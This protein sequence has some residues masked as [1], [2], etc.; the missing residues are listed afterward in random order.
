[1]KTLQL[2]TEIA[3][4]PY[5]AHDDVAEIFCALGQDGGL[6][7]RENLPLT[8]PEQQFMDLLDVVV[9]A[10]VKLVEAEDTYEGRVTE[11][12]SKV[13]L[14][15]PGCQERQEVAF[16]TSYLLHGS[17]SASRFLQEGIAAATIAL[18]A[19]MPRVAGERSVALLP[20]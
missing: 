4:E 18:R 2:I 3:E 8:Q 16:A 7:D 19:R 14:V 20:V 1:M 6:N 17:K 10:M 9:D 13:R 5:T 12:P 11:D 15:I